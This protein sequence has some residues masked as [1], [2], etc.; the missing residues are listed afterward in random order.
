MPKV[1]RSEFRTFIDKTPETSD[2]ALIGEGVT[3]GEISYNPE[4]SEEVYIHEDSGSTDVESYKPSMAIEAVAI[5][6]DDVF[7]FIDRLR[8][9]RA[10]LSDAH[11]QIVNVWLYEEETGGEYPAELQDVAISIESFGG[12]GGESAKINYTIH[13]RGDP[14]SGT[15]NPSTLTW[16]P[17]V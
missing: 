1:K 17:D 3:S 15:F 8:K 14:V 7:E 16:T 12:E 5:N 11:T 13:F 10:V 4:T 6:G 9:D 2:W